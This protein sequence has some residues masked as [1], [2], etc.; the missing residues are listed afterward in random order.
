MGL[1]EQAAADLQSILEDTSGFGWEIT[2]RNPAGESCEMI[3]L[4]N[5]VAQTIDPQTGIAVSGRIASIALSLKTLEDDQWWLGMPKGITDR[6]SKPWVVTFNDIM[7]K[8]HTFKI[9]EANPDRAA[10]I[11]TCTLE[12][13]VP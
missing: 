8:P 2:L 9:Q 10:G 5:D 7:G 3:G 13:Y 1:R 4:S 12:S 6:T 11:V